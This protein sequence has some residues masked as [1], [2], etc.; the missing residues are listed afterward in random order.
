MFCSKCGVQLPETSRFCDQCGAAQHDAPEA[1]VRNTPSIEPLAAESA[2][3]AGSNRVEV[4]AKTPI[5]SSKDAAE[6]NAKATAAEEKPQKSSMME[7]GEVFGST[8]GRFAL[9]C[10]Y[11]PPKGFADAPQEYPPKD[12]SSFNGFMAYFYDDSL[13]N[14]ILKLIGKHITRYTDRFH[15]AHF[16]R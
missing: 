1:P 6:G 10:V 9:K 4:S 12:T 14:H 13:D 8:S 2:Q 11:V 3:S 5:Q 15:A 16:Q 7:S